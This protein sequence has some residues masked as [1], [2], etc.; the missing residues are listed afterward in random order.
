MKP[1]MSK[2]FS[3]RLACRTAIQPAGRGMN[4]SEVPA[5]ADRFGS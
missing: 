2:T 3:H 4:I 1:S 5:S